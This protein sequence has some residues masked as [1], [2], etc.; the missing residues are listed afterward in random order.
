MSPKEQLVAL[1]ACLHGSRKRI[2]DNI[3]RAHRGQEMTD[4]LALDIYVNVKARLM[5]FTETL[6][7]RQLRLR[8]EWG[9][10]TKGRHMTALQF[11]AAWEELLAGLEEA[12]LA[13]TERVPCL[14]SKAR[15]SAW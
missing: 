10:L 12:G 11:E 3:V 8:R 4:A 9:A 5:Q 2:Y 7:E 6:M 14:H 1:K 13:K 15:P